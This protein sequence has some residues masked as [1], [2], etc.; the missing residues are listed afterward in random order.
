MFA[1]S[2]QFVL[3]Q[4]HVTCAAGL[5]R[6]VTRVDISD[7]QS[8]SLISQSMRQYFLVKAEGIALKV[9][10]YPLAEVNM[11]IVFW[12]RIFQQFAGEYH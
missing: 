1:D 5:S 12:I 9:T 3:F 7:G 8:P 11:L 4:F 6:H 10:D 2:D